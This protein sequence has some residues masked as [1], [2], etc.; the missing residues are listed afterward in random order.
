M[1]S[2]LLQ[3]VLPQQGAGT[4]EWKLRSRAVAR[5]VSACAC[6]W[7]FPAGCCGSQRPWESRAVGLEKNV[8][9]SCHTFRRCDRH[10]W[11]WCGISQVP[12]GPETGLQNL[13][14][15][16]PSPRFPQTLLGPGERVVGRMKAKQRTQAGVTLPTWASLP[17]Q[18]LCFS[19]T[20]TLAMWPSLF[21]ECP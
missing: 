13:Y 15:L 6:S 3:I 1:A 20:K 11:R 10:R 19:S 18:G 5:V 21:A 8:T 17:C 9:V 2:C 14:L 4:R 16:Y 7:P 12:G